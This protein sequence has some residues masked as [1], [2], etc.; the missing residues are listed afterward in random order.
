MNNPEPETAHKS[1]GRIKPSCQRRYRKDVN[2]HGVMRGSK[3]LSGS[4]TKS[5]SLEGQPTLMGA[6]SLH[7]DYRLAS[8]RPEPYSRRN[9]PASSARPRPSLL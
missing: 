2:L 3:D 4:E 5:M 6:G 9:S 7:P 8:R 1:S